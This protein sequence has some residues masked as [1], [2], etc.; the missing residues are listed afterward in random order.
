[1]LKGVAPHV[2]VWWRTRLWSRKLPATSTIELQ[3]GWPLLLLPFLLFGQLVTPH[4][5]WIV[6]LVTIAALYAIGYGWVREQVQRVRFTRRRAG[7]ILVAGDQLHEEFAVVNASGLPLLWAA[8]IDASDLPGY[9]PGVVVAC[10]PNQD[11]RWRTTA[12]CARRGVFRLGPHHLELGDPFGLFR[13]AQ[14]TDEFE[15]VLIY[16]RVV[17]LPEVALPRGGADAHAR[18]RRSMLGTRPAASVRDYIA[19]DSMRLVHWPTTAHRGRLT[20]KELEQEPSGDVWLVLDLDAAVQQGAGAEG[21][22]EYGVMLA[23]SL[24]AEM[25]SGADRRAVGLLA[26]AGDAV[27]SL[28]PQPGQAQLW[29]V[30][31]ALAPAQPSST[32]LHELLRRSL[33][34]LGRRHTLLVITPACGDSA[35][36]W[37]AELV[38]ASGQGLF[39]SVLAVTTPDQAEAATAA[40]T[41][42]AQLD[43]PHQLLRTDARLRAALTYRRTRKVIRTTPTGGAFT[44]EV[45]EEVG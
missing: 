24:A 23:A 26:A 31:A 22:L 8:F 30:M 25:V 27:I 17:Q 13:A 15:T 43:I 38:R 29:S 7:A 16:P 34:L 20:V 4:P 10:G 41:L 12:E 37:I 5:V 6:L 11:Y 18:R 3:I 39:S 45:E 40:L 42:L 32:P 28:A 21:T 33:P 9:T 35:P 2:G 19:G 14:T 36:L 44:V 1:M